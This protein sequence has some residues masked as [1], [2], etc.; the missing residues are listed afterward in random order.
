M[1]QSVLFDMDGLMFDTEPLWGA[2]WQ[3]ALARFGLTYK[4]GLDEAARGTAGENL[5][6]VVRR[7]YG[8]DCP[9][10]GILAAFDEIAHQKFLEPV[11]KK[12]GLDALLA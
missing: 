10:E 9:V 2:S 12:P 3:P 8:P 7:Y 6:A 4:E 11:P 1:I 5:R